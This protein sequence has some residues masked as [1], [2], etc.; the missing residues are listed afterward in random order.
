MIR[1]LP[2]CGDRLTNPRFPSI[3]CVIFAIRGNE[4]YVQTQHSNQ[5]MTE[6]NVTRHWYAFKIFFGKGEPIKA[7]F[8]SQ[9]LEC[10]Y[11]VVKSVTT[12]DGKPRQVSVPVVPT[13]IFLR[14]TRYEAEIAERTFLNKIMLYRYVDA[15]H[16]KIPAIVSD[17][18]IDIFKIVANSG[19]EGLDFYEEYNPKYT[20]G[21]KVR[22]TAGIFKG[23]EGYVVRIKGNRHLYVSIKG[24]CAVTTGYIPKAHLMKIE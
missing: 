5:T 8:E 22:V 19:V 7:Y 20:K 4:R 12:K 3:A 10:F 18:E 14:S 24:F 13:L 11:D 6:Q 17:R 1:G 2:L 21:D 16:M 15:S 23:A 9:K